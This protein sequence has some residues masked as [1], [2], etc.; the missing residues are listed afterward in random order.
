[1]APECF[2]AI[3]VSEC[4]VTANTAI[5]QDHL[6]RNVLTAADTAWTP[7]IRS[8]KGWNDHLRFDFRTNTRVTMVRIFLKANSRRP[9]KVSVLVSNSDVSWDVRYTGSFPEN[10]EIIISPAA[11]ARYAKLN[12]DEYEETESD[13][14]VVGIRQVTWIGCFVPAKSSNFACKEDKTKVSSE[15]TQ[16]RHVAYDVF[17]EIFY[18]CDVDPKTYNLVCRGNIAG[19]KKFIELPESVAYIVGYSAARGRM[20]FMDFNE[21]LVSSNDGVSITSHLGMKTEDLED[22]NPSTVIPGLGSNMPMVIIEDYK[23]D[24]YGVIFKEEEVLSWSP[25]CQAP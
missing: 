13:E 16:Y 19:T 11:E 15:L 2:D 14:V 8:G 5:D 25:C 22:L 6:P 20:F 17:N 4:G 7:A 18:F 21:N 24:F 9:S 10:G 12:F 1:M 23:V 3:K